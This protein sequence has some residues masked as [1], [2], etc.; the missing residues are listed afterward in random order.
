MTPVNNNRTDYEQMVDALFKK[1]PDTPDTFMHACAGLVGEFGELVDALKKT[2]VYEKPLDRE[3]LLEE[4]GDMYFYFTALRMMF[5]IP[6]APKTTLQNVLNSAPKIAEEKLVETIMSHAIS[7]SGLVGGIFSIIN[8]SFDADK[9]A[10][11]LAIMFLQLELFIVAVAH[12][13]GWS[14]EAIEEAN[15]KKLAVRYPDKVFKAEH[16]QARMDKAHEPSPILQ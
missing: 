13:F 2:W 7:N 10:P 9:F 11:T 3:N 14:K 6:P 1:F 4:L 8:K 5:E 16:A 15:M 12:H